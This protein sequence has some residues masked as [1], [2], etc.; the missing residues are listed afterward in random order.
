MDINYLIEREASRRGLSPKTAKTYCNCI[1]KFFRW[2]KKEPREVTKHDVKEYL[3]RLADRNA[4]GSTL[5]VH[6][7]A[8][9]FLMGE[10]LNKRLFLD[11]KYSRIPKTLPEFLT[12][13]EV[14]RLFDA[15]GNRKHQLM[16]KLLYAT[17]MRVSELASLKV[18][19]FQFDQ[20]YGWVRQGKGRKDR[21]FVIAV[22]LKDELLRWIGANKLNYED[23]LF[24][25]QGRRHISAQTLYLIVKRAAKKAGIK[26]KVHPHTLRHSFA[27]HLIQ[28]GYAVTEVQP[29]MGH[30]KMETTMI[31]LHMAS[32]NLLSVESPFDSLEVGEC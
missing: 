2:C 24:Q 27:T 1:E 11:F 16:I 13:E 25:G 15:I 4:S 23:W 30:S 29:L 6:L 12:K 3:N 21:L 14:S 31:Y 20:N 9:K 32:P 26:K 7:S 10:I 22:K 8:I 5:N 18:R 19:D 17:G 28:N